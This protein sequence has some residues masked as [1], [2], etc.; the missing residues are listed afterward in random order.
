M[1]NK[2][3]FY[4]YTSFIIYYKIEISKRKIYYELLNTCSKKN[5]LLHEKCNDKFQFLLAKYI[6]HTHLYEICL[7]EISKHIKQFIHAIQNNLSI[8]ASEKKSLFVLMFW[9]KKQFI[10]ADVPEKNSLFMLIFRKK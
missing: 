6:F 10:H 2:Q 1:K 7:A 9:K 5:P 3:D 4:S 8:Y